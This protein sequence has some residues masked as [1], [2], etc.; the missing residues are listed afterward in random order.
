MSEESNSGAAVIDRKFMD[1]YSRQ[2]GTYGMDTMVKLISLKVLVLGCR[3]VG[4][5]AVKNITLAGVHT[6]SIYDPAKA[7][8]CDMGANFCI[9]D[10]N[11][12]QGKTRGELTASLAEQLNPNTR[13]A[14]IAALTDD[15]I[16]AHDV[17]IV[18]SGYANLSE[19]E[20]TRINAVCRARD[21]IASFIVCLDGGIVGSLFVDHGPKF[22]TRDP[23]GRQALQ[24]SITE[25]VTR[26]DKK[27]RKYTRLR[28]AT[29]EGMQPGALRDTTQLT[30]SEVKGLCKPDGTSVNDAGVFDGVVGLAD[31][32]NT[33]R[34]YPSLE[35]RGFTTPYVR[36][37][38]IHEAKEVIA[39]DFRT[40]AE[41]LAMPPPVII[42][43]SM[44]DGTAESNVH[45]FVHALLR[46]GNSTNGA[47]P[48]ANDAAA[49]D[50]ICAVAEKIN[51]AGK[52]AAATFVPPAVAESPYDPESEMPSPMPPPPPPSPFVCENMDADLI[53]NAARLVGAQLQPMC[54]VLGAIVAQEV[55]K[56][57][58]KF[59]P[60]YQ[61]LHMHCGALLP[62]TAPAD[63]APKKDRYD[64][65][66]AIF[67]DAFVQKLNNLNMFMVGCGALGCENIKNF[68][69]NGIACGPKGRLIVT[70]NDR[71]E[72]SNLNRQF[73]FRDDNIGQP[74]SVAAA[75]RAQT[76]NSAMKIE[77]M[78]E[79]V[80]DTTEH[81]FTD[82][83]W[84]ALDVVTNALDNMKARLYVDAKC[85]LHEKVLVEA[86]TMGTG[87]N[88]DIIVPHKTT[89]YAEGG[90]A[91]QTGG[92][93]MC[94]LRNFPYIFDH[95]IEWARAQF[96]DVFVSPMMTAQLLRENPDAFK[97]KMIKDVDC[98]E[99][100]G[101]KQSFIAKNAK[102]LRGIQEVLE[103]LTKP[104]VTMEDC[105]ELA[106]RAFHNQFRD[107][108]ASLI[109]C[110]PADAKKSNGEPFWSG[111]R[112]FPTALDADMD[113]YP[114]VLEFLIAASNLYAC[115]LGVH[116]EKHPPVQNDPNARW[117]AQYRDP[118]W[119]K[120]VVAKLGVPDVVISA[121]DDLDEE[122]A[123]SSSAAKDAA[124]DNAKAEAAY[125]AQLDG[126]VAAAASI[127]PK[128]AP[129]D[130]E[131]DDDDNFHIDF[132]AAASNLRALN[133]DIATKTR[134]D[135]K[136]VA[137][138]IIPAIATTTAAVTGFALI[139]LFKVLQDKDVS[140][141][142]NG[143]IDLGSNIYTMFDRDPPKKV[144]TR[145]EKTYY[146]EQDYTE[147][148][149]VVAFPNPH[150][151]YD[152]VRVKVTPSTTVADFCDAL[153]A[154]TE[155]GEGGP[156]EVVGLG[157]G[158]GLLWNGIPS[159]K[160]YKRPLLECIG[161]LVSDVDAFR[162][163]KLYSGVAVNMENAD[164]DEVV[165]A[166][167][168]LDITA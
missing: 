98:A 64:D 17:V 104:S 135:V 13:V 134:M 94:T 139:E 65:L 11:V 60:V 166:T 62:E 83:F 113:K 42:T 109:K 12:G 40:F 79:L 20:L 131:K 56:V 85:I 90:D 41:C 124:N 36:G 9:T 130:F 161:E 96:D 142:L 143:M 146:P 27:G 112:K 108:I 69:L 150:T 106:W 89:S 163:K 74:K 67:G 31:P 107:K 152:K 140:L 95:C 28:L 102:T 162:K 33:V 168:V 72:V 44:M 23:D 149:N 114:D 155:S 138:K 119:L 156:Y 14:N 97:N 6:V 100:E 151:N 70:D 51:A 126:V 99:N 68:A 120:G 167:V 93:P 10:A 8:A 59:T 153:Q 148:R 127:N 43:N 137:G 53:K 38:F 82:D 157:A 22:V 75:K 92:I 81:I 115:M 66:R 3:G 46:H 76:M 39:R 144:K 103:L 63:A 37:G 32:P 147:E 91:D 145:V 25:V 24:K 101:Q 49:T 158:T 122:T 86:G 58:G 29:P 35:E 73:L 87:G 26:E 128:A 50:A 21:P 160:N 154:Q 4:A 133:Y 52:E 78:Q 71:I 15:V 7:T 165:L 55:V 110:F 54:A 121:V 45:L 19:N 1:L 47:L 164:G 61:F 118:A 129:L 116:G 48:A 2:I 18:T 30:F 84:E 111:H 132:V 125:R 88:V 5:E 16:K 159:H 80:G 141:L 34:I 77:A 57:T 105:V 117:M 136:L 123:A